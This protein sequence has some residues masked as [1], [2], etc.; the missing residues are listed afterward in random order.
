MSDASGIEVRQTPT[1][2]KAF[3]RLGEGQKD[4]VDEEIGRII[5]N[6]DLGTRKRGDLSHLRVHKFEMDNQQVLLGYSWDAGRL[7]I[8]LLNMGPHENFYKAA[9]RRRDAD[10]KFI[11]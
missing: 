4:R 2:K 6:P 8:T 10:L 11:K 7:I 1:F 3:Q 9:K 5:D